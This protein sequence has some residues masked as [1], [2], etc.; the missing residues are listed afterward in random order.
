[1]ATQAGATIENLGLEDVDLE[2]DTS[3]GGLVGLSDNSSSINNSYATGTVTGIVSIGG[4][5]GGMM[6]ALL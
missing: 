3:V 5:V 1:M 6:A 4:L 2:G